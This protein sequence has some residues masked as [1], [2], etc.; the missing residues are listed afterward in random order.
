MLT[1]KERAE[2][3][4][5][6]NTL[7]T[8]LMVGKDGVTENVVAEAD[9]LLTARELV[10]GKVLESALMTAR[11]VSDE[12]CEATGAEGISCVGNKFVIWRFS[13]KCQEERNQTGRAK[14]KAIPVSKSNPVRK[15]A[16]AR[17]LAQKQV[18]EQ[19]NEYFRQQAIEKS[20][21][22]A[23]EKQLRGED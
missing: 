6:A 21:E 8:T 20:I 10:K 4:A 5:Q 14:R 2:F 15:G 22:K 3:R 12:I 19:R 9:K 13:E 23:R 7:D 18:R 17:R 1:S 16:K 11:E